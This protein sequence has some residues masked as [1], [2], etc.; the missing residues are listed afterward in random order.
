MV[1]ELF[2]RPERAAIA[3][4]ATDYDV[5]IVGAGMVGLSLAAALCQTPLRVAM[6]EATEPLPADAQRDL[7]ASAIAAGSA[8]IL[9]QIGVWP[10][11]QSLGVSPIHRVQISDQ[12][13]P[14]ATLH[15]EE[16]GIAALGY[17]VENWVTLQ[18]LQQ[19]LQTA[20]HLI[21]MRPARVVA[22]AP[23]PTHMQVTIHRGNDH[24]NLTT[25][26][27]VAADGRQSPLRHLAQIPVTG[28]AYD[29]AL[30]VCI[31]TTENPHRQTGYERF[32]ASGPFAILPMVAPPQ[33]P[34]GH[35]CCIIWTAKSTEKE[36]LLELDDDT[37]MAALTPRLSPEL[38]RILSV[39]PR[40]CY[41]PRRQHADRY[42]SDR[43][44]LV[45]DAAHATHPVGGQGFNMGV[46]DVAT[47][48]HLLRQA[49]ARGE[50]LGNP[51]LLRTYEQQRQPDNGTVLWGTDLAN[52]LFSNQCRSI[53]LGRRLALRG[54]DYLLPLKR[55]LIRYAMGLAPQQTLSA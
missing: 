3:N 45:G 21:Y 33:Q 19:R 16:V 17:V 6:V 38:G 46:R 2:L 55:Q 35:R 14:L 31:I 30:I 5:L 42:C 40:A 54:C 23:H 51:R 20:S 26:L 4:G 47:L 36:I 37:F 8:Q 49:Q 11:M 7:R 53:Q 1:S 44:V 32:Q 48:A 34:D 52:R 28:W 13:V 25:Q 43:L 15:R 9:E 18:A 10:I 39:S 12:G 50:D 41:R 29:Q 27:L 24:L 22:I